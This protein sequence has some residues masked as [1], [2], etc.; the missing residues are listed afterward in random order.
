M[1]ATVGMEPEGR[2]KV[3]GW[4]LTHYLLSDIARLPEQD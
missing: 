2:L 4:G 1:L 3:S